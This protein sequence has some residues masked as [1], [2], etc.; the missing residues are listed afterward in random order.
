[1]GLQIIRCNAFDRQMALGITLL[2]LWCPSETSSILSFFS[3]YVMPPTVKTK[4][5]AGFPNIPDVTGSWTP[6]PT[7]TD[8]SS[9]TQY[10]LSHPY[11]CAKGK[12]A[13]RC[14]FAERANFQVT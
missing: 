4:K 1:M 3:T 14:L 6:A 13:E 2:R 7:K 11:A 9:K 12:P 8:R 10:L 5:G